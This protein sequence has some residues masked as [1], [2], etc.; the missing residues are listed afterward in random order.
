MILRTIVNQ[1]KQFLLSIISD[2][3]I[4]KFL[5]V[6]V[7]NA[8]ILIGLTIVLTDQLNIF[9]LHS[10]IISFEITIIIGFFIN[11]FWTFSKKEHSQK[12]FKRFVKYQIFYII[13]LLLNGIILF[14]L[15]DY[16]S[17]HYSFS[18]IIAIFCVFLWNFYS[19]K[20]ITFK[21]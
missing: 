16:F 11:N 17:V 21:S 14:V 2:P 5:T 18:Q 4:Y 7:V 12:I 13:G 3:E 1:L 9:Y 10:S 6:G 19:S 15:T 8:G 20:K